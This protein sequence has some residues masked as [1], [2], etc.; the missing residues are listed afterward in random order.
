MNDIDILEDYQFYIA[1]SVDEVTSFITEQLDNAIR[2]A[3][4]STGYT[5]QW[6]MGN[7]DRINVDIFPD[8]I[9][10][11]SN[12]VFKVDKRTIFSLRYEKN[13]VSHVNPRLLLNFEISFPNI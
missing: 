3:F 7:R 11:S 12:M 5:E 4:L 1:K 6:L 9:D 2:K 8:Q 10:G 13:E